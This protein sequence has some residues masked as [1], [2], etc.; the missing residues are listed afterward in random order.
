MITYKALNYLILYQQIACSKI[1]T[2]ERWLFMKRFHTK[3]IN[4][5][6]EDVNGFCGFCGFSCYNASCS[7]DC[8]TTCVGGCKGS[9]KGT[10]VNTCTSCTAYSRF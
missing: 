7:L 8:N 1:K 9:C 6:K 3:K 2:Y 5:V 10:C 4:Q